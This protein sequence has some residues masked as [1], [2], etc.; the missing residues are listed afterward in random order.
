[1]PTIDKSNNIKRIMFL[2]VYE[3]DEK[4]KIGDQFVTNHVKNPALLVK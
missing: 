1:M 3:H 2:S 4:E